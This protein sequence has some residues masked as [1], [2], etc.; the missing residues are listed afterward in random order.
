MCF[1]KDQLEALD[2]EKERQREQRNKLHPYYDDL[3]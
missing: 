1:T 3:L 2:G